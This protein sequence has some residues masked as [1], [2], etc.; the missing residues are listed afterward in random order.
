MN[1]SYLLDDILDDFT[2]EIENVNYSIP[3]LLSTYNEH[4]SLCGSFAI[5]IHRK[6]Y[7]FL[8]EDKYLEIRRFLR[9]SAIKDLETYFGFENKKWC[10]LVSNNLLL[11]LDLIFNELNQ[12]NISLYNHKND[13]KISIFLFYDK[14]LRVISET[15]CSLCEGFVEI[16]ESKED[17]LCDNCEERLNHYYEIN[18]LSVE[19]EE[20]EEFVFDDLDLKTPTAPIE[21]INFDYNNQNEIEGY[22]GH[23]I[24]GYT[25]Y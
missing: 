24:E 2:N 12:S 13:M 8:L 15:N 18:S 5:T 3:E 14:Y 20:E 25:Y 23:Q 1:F 4:R 21:I 9:D 17:T 6:L 11:Y 7:D 22:E 19:E 16:G 10:K